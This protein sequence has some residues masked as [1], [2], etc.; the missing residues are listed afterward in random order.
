M[1]RLGPLVLLLL[2]PLGAAACNRNDQDR[3]QQTTDSAADEAQRA[4]HEIGQSLQQLGEDARRTVE[5]AADD[6][7]SSSQS[8]REAAA[9]NG[10][11]AV[12]QSEFRRQG[13]EL[14]GTPTCSA[15]SPS[16][17]V[18]HV[19]CTG[20]TTD[21]KAVTLVGDDPGDGPSTF[22]GSVEGRE[23]FRQPCVGLC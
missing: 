6:L 21:G 13:V 19:E 11:A 22:V 16:I 2:L 1:R 5:R 10:I 17:G 8:V 7:R 4:G 3:A 20:Q 14:T 12:A 15:T 23:V 18:Y 9:R